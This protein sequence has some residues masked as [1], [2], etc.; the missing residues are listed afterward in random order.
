MA[1]PLTGG[2]GASDADCDA[3][4]ATPS[5]TTSDAVRI[6]VLQ[7]PCSSRTCRCC[8]FGGWRAWDGDLSSGL[9]GMRDEFGGMI[10]LEARRKS[11][12]DVGWVKQGRYAGWYRSRKRM[13][14][15]TCS[16]DNVS[17]V[18]CAVGARKE[19]SWPDV[20]AGRAC[21]LALAGRD[22]QA[23]RWTDLLK[24]FNKIASV[25]A[26]SGRGALTE[27]MA[28]QL[29]ALKPV[30]AC[31]FKGSPALLSIELESTQ[32]VICAVRGSYSG[33][34]DDKGKA[35]EQQK[36]QRYS[37]SARVGARSQREAFTA[38]ILCSRRSLSHCRDWPLS[39]PL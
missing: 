34:S 19:G 29:A 25:R 31:S 26:S 38:L 1:Q 23:L 24:I 21:V 35:G 16:F 37:Q 5:S 18:L 14:G 30:S 3:A 8:L 36:R 13:S 6:E 17:W 9:S 33:R 27:A 2:G 12:N 10:G 28:R 4:P 22:P 32:D 15:Q 7:T 39:D 11:E 20:A